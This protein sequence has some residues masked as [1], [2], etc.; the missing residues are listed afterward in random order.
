MALDCAPR[1]LLSPTS[2]VRLC[3]RA[4]WGEEHS[5]RAGL[6]MRWLLVC[7]FASVPVL[8]LQCWAG[9]VCYF[10]GGCVFFTLSGLSCCGRR[11]AALHGMAYYYP[12]AMSGA[13]VETEAR[14]VGDGPLSADG[15]PSWA[16]M[17]R[18]RVVGLSVSR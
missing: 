9:L 13:A 1:V 14:E 17:R 2:L 3:L 7:L 12:R 16:P 15:F 8:V 18:R 11:V 4:C 10:E 5:S 6:G